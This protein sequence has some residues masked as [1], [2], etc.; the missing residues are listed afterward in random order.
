MNQKNKRILLISVAVILAIHT[1]SFLHQVRVEKASKRA[2][3][4]KKMMVR[5]VPKALPKKSLKKPKQ[6]VNT[7]QTGRKKI[8]DQTKFLGKTT[9]YFDRQTIARN[10]DKYKEAGKGNSRKT[11]VQKRQAQQKTKKKPV[12]KK[13]IAKATK[14]KKLKKGL[15]PKKKLTLAD[16]SFNTNQPEPK[17]EVKEA[18]KVAGLQFGKNGKTGLGQNNDYVDDIP[19]GDMTKLNTVEFKYYGFYHRIRQKLEQYWGNSLQKKAQALFKAGKKLVMDTDK[20]TALIIILDNKGQIVKIDVKSTSGVK[21]LDDA[22]IES[23]NRAGPFPNPPRGMLKNGMAY[24]E[25]GFVVKS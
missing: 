17:P 7:D 13:K 19:L 10:T 1:I 16:L 25:W 14:K 24:L 2:F 5:I 8:D 4:P 11:I 12:K 23:F 15:G 9:Q 21:E 20:I 18:R 6:I 3:K 22:A